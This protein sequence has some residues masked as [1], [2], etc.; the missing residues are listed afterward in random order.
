[1]EGARDGKPFATGTT[2]LCGRIC[3]HITLH[4]VPKNMY[5]SF[6]SNSETNVSELLENL[7]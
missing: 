6:S 5:S 4:I 3:E 1:M 7:E 2:L